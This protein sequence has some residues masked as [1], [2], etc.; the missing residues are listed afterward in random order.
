MSINIDVALDEYEEATS[1][2]HLEVLASLMDAHFGE[3]V[4]LVITRR[5]VRD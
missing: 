5:L 3:G 4:A 2:S 1:L